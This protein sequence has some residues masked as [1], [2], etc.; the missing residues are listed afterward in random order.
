MIDIFGRA[1]FACA[2]MLEFL[3]I[4]RFSSFY[5]KFYHTEETLLTYKKIRTN[6]HN[7]IKLTH[8]ESLIGLVKI[9]DSFS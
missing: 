2:C 1:G 4:S 6:R 5:F 3:N 8:D 9:M 7:Q